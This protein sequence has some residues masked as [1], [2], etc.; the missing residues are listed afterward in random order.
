MKVTEMI[1][2]VQMLMCRKVTQTREQTVTPLFRKI[3]RETGRNCTLDM[4]QWN[5]RQSDKSEFEGGRE[6]GTEENGTRNI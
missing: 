2:R 4:V 1:I 6:D 3:I 5:I